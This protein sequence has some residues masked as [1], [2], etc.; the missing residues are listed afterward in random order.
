MKCSRPHCLRAL[1]RHG[2]C[3]PHWKSSIA[4]GL[5][6]LT[7]S[8]TVHEHIGRL[9]VLQWSD[10]G[11]AHMAGVAHSTVPHVLASTQVQRATERAFLSVPLVPYT[12]RKV[13]IPVVGLVRR[14]DALACLGW[15]L[16]VLAP[17]AGTTAQAV[18]NAQR[19]GQVSVPLHNRF[20][21]VY[22]GIQNVKGPSETVAL[23]ARNKGLYPPIVWD[24]DTI[25][26]P[27]AQPNLTGFDEL[28]VRDLM[29]GERVAYASEVDRVEA[30]A[31]LAEAGLLPYEIGR[32]MG[33]RLD[34]VLA[35]L[36]KEAA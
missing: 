9:R 35:R 11:I 8:A 7:D 12:S 22:D 19:R 27:A 20:A 26:D 34:T 23:Q 3:L 31:R 6:G 29:D 25:D 5:N 10:I 14:R 21:A 32:L 18:C 17:M 36:A 1:R 4:L 24:E 28:T 16:V 13:T 30:T 15:P 2:L 33:C